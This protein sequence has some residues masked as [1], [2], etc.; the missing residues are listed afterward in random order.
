[1]STVN[2]QREERINELHRHRE[3]LIDRSEAFDAAAQALLASQTNQERYKA[4]F[5]H[6]AN[7]LHRDAQQMRDNAKVCDDE[8]SRLNLHLQASRR[9]NT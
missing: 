2:H 3:A 5:V 1:M 7:R 6:I 8:I 4:D 9:M